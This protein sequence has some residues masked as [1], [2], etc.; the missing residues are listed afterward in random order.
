MTPTV[1]FGP[2]SAQIDSWLS[3]Y[4]ELSLS[5]MGAR[6][7]AIKTGVN[8]WGNPV[9][10]SGTAAPSAGVPVTSTNTTQAP[11][12]FT[13]NIIAGK[14]LASTAAEQRRRNSTGAR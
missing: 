13:G 12:Y 4:S 2:A 5:G 6:D 8:P 14:D 3:K 9:I 1:N 11:A 7:R 10:G